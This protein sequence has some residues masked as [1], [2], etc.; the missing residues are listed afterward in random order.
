MLEKIKEAVGFIES[1]LPGKPEFAIVL[2]SGLGKLQEE[3]NNPVTIDYQDIPNFP[4][5]TVKGHS[6]K[7]IYGEIEGKTVLMMAGRFHYYEGYDM[8][9][10]TFP[11]RVFKGLGIEKVILSNASG[12]V[13]P[14]YSVGDAVV[15]NDHINMMPEHPLRGKNEDALGPRF[16]NMSHPYDEK[17][18]DF[19]VNYGK[20]NGIEVKT[21]IYLGLQGPT[22]ETPAEYGMVRILGADCVGMSTVPEVIVANHQSMRVFCISVI[23]DLGGPEIRVPVSH[24]EVLSAADKAMPKII[25]LVKALIGNEV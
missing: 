3:V 9:E 23:T 22:F 15:I 1:I 25:E 19:V 10:V 2:G 11:M 24:E 6:G 13:N 18:I 5:T 16:V 21:G 12:G 14:D 8:K 17:M 4:Q 20:Q 7:L